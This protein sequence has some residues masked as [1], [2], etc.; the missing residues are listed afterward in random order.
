MNLHG[1]R[2][3]YFDAPKLLLPMLMTAGIFILCIECNTLYNCRFNHNNDKRIYCR[4]R[5]KVKWL[6]W[7]TH[8]RIEIPYIPQVLRSLRVEEESRDSLR[9]Q[10]N[11]A[12]TVYVRHCIS[13]LDMCLFF[14]FFSDEWR[15]NFRWNWDVQRRFLKSEREW[16]SNRSQL[17]SLCLKRMQMLCCVKQNIS[18]TLLPWNV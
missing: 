5:N 1:R 16:I 13:W 2:I 14:P 8:R 7:L 12:T 3:I 4:V 18:K 9:I 10:M 15:M 6:T 11:L 17:F